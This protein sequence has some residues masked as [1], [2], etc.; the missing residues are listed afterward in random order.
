M[1]LEGA[2]TIRFSCSHEELQQIMETADEQGRVLLPP[3][4]SFGFPG[5]WDVVESLKSYVPLAAE[6]TVRRSVD[7]SDEGKNSIAESYVD[8]IAWVQ[9]GSYGCGRAGK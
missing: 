7:I 2:V 8:D 4:F 3:R 5:P 6:M 1:S 9:V